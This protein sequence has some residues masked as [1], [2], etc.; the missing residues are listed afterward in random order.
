MSLINPDLIAQARAAIEKQAILPISMPVG[1]A[2]G[3]A[4]A[5]RHHGLKGAVRGA[6]VGLT[7]GLGVPVG[8]LTGAGVG[9]IGGGLAGGALGAG[10]SGIGQLIANGKIDPELLLSHAGGGASLGGGL[11]M[12]GGG[13]GGAVIGG[14]EGYDIGKRY[15]WG[16]PWDRELPH[17][18]TGADN[19]DDDD[20][21]KTASYAARLGALAAQLTRK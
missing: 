19:D 7:T 20:R 11:G 4:N 5:P 8:L 6:G 1:A 10:A 14:Q 9:G 21:R 2:L 13:L 12:I 16:R 17:G 18:V 3:Y 15:I